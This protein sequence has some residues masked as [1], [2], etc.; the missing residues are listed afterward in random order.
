MKITIL[1]ENQAGHNGSRFILAEWGLSLLIEAD[2]VNILFD[3]GHTNVYWRNA[4]QLKVNLNRTNFIVLSQH[5]WDHVGGLQ[6]HGFKTKKKLVAHPELIAQLPAKE[7]RKI[8]TDFRIIASAEPLEF[9]QGIFYLGEIPRV[10]NFEK[11]LFKRKQMPDDS[12]MAIKTKN[13]AVVITGC[14]HSGICNICQ[15]AK[16]V[17]GQKLYAVIGGFHLFENDP[18]AVEGTVRYFKKEQPKHIYPMHCIDLSNLARFH[19]EFGIVKFS[20]G[21][22]IQL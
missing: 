21:D 20:A 22:T 6:H 14:S 10:N 1:C 8:K 17:T 16:Q 2:A 9:S 5:H 19:H 15:Y 4:E 18:K 12:A 7:S 3:A 13:G 11:G